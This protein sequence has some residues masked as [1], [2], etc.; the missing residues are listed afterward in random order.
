MY[1]EVLFPSE[2]LGDRDLILVCSWEKNL[3]IKSF[4]ICF[5]ACFILFFLFRVT[6]FGEDRTFWII[7]R[8]K[9]Y[10]EMLQVQEITRSLL[11]NMHYVSHRD[12]I[13]WKLNC[14][15]FNQETLETVFLSVSFFKSLRF[16]KAAGLL[17][18]RYRKSCDVGDIKG[19]KQENCQALVKTGKQRQRPWFWKKVRTYLK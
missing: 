6:D 16:R 18:K 12:V 11:S 4:F 3:P 10:G 13:T 19:I 7:F 5:F 8:Y 9:A 15:H 1:S 2:S 14:K 17:S